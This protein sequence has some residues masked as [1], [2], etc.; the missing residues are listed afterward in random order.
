MATI[1]KDAKLIENG[2]EMA[3]VQEIRLQALVGGEG[4]QGFPGPLNGELASA[5]GGEHLGQV[6]SGEDVCRVGLDGT[7]KMRER[8]R[9]SDLAKRSRLA[10]ARR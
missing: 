1:E 3:G 7:G 2:W 6:E 10:L 5:R 4:V 9:A 8:P